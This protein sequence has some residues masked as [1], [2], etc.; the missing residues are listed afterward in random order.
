MNIV[1]KGGDKGQTSLIGGRRISKADLR[2][3]AC[4]STDELGAALGCCLACGLPSPFAEEIENIQRVLFRLAADLADARP[5]AAGRITAADT[6]ALE[7]RLE[8]HLRQLPPLKAFILCGGSPA[9]AQL[10]L[11]RTVCRRAERAC[12]RLAETTDCN[13]H[14]AANPAPGTEQEHPMPKTS[15]QPD[16]STNPHILTYLNRLSDYLYAAARL[17]NLAQGAAEKEV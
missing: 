7:A 8:P 15:N 12:V 14:T 5:G 10:H 17:V 16:P 13:T 2:M 11:A 9:G 4:G 1:T 3:E 6:A